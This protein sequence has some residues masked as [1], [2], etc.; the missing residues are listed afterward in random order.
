M[1]NETSSFDISSLRIKSGVKESTVAT[2]LTAVLYLRVSTKD[3]AARG[4][5][6]E[7]FSIPAQRDAVTRKAMSLGATIVQEFIDAGESARSADRPELQ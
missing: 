7:G 5:D 2:P 3:Q 4:N 6:L 1:A